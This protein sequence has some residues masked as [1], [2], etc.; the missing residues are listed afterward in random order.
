M[1]IKKLFIF[2]SFF[3]V[4]FILSPYSKSDHWVSQKPNDW[5]FQ[6]RAYP[7]TEINHEQYVEGIKHLQSIKKTSLWKDEKVWEFAGPTNIGGRLTDVEMHPDVPQTMFYAAASGGVFKSV[8]GGESFYPVFDDALSLSIGD[9]AIAPSDPDIIYVGTGEA[10]CGGG[11]LAYEGVG[12]FRSQDNGETWDFAGLENSRN[13]GRM[14]VDPTDPQTIYVAAMGSLFAN[15]PDRGIYKSTDAG[16]TW[17]KVLFVNDSTGGIDLVIHPENPDILYAAMWERV[18]RPHRRSY[19]GTGCGIFRSIDAGLSWTELT[20]GLPS[21]SPYVGRIGID[22]CEADPDVLY[23]IYA[24]N[25]GYFEGIYKTSDMG[26]TWQA[27]NDAGLSGCYSSYGWWFGR[28]EVDPVDPD[29]AYAIAFDL[30]KTASGGNSWSNISSYYTHVDQ[31][32]LYIQPQNHDNLL[33][34]NDGGL[35]FSSNGGSSWAIL[36]ELPITQ[37][38]TCE[39]DYQYPQRLYG[40]TQDNGTNRTMSGSLDDWQ[41]IY[42]G[43]GFYALVDPQD[44]SYVYAEYQYGN[45]VRSTNGGNSFYSAMTG[46]SSGDRMNWNTPVVFDPNNPSVLYYGANRLYKSTNRAQNWNAI[47]NDLSN[48]S[49]NGNL[50]YGTI[51]TIDVSPL[52]ANLIYVGTDDG[53]VWRTDDGGTNWILLS[54]SLPQRWITRVVSD[55]VTLD[56]LYVTLSGFRWNEFLPH[57]YKSEDRGNTWTAIANGLPELPVNDLVVDPDNEEKLYLA[58]DA[59]VFVSSNGGNTWGIM[60]HGLPAVVINDLEIHQ[61]SRKLVAAT[62]GRSMYT[63]DLH[64]D[65]ITGQNVI[66]KNNIQ[67]EVYPNPARDQLTVHFDGIEEVSVYRIQ[68]FDNTGKLVLD[69]PNIRTPKYNLHFSSTDTLL[70]GVYFIYIFYQERIFKSKLIILP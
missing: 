24:D 58:T 63:Y 38:Y 62:F 69:R 56:R 15:S 25:I 54:E 44:N 55:P 9:I 45:F 1:I 47:S 2:L 4:S 12:V 13:I 28:I 5:F 46:I 59:A 65:T 21:P 60:G 14:V 10:N 30:Y 49:G 61:P 33:L 66:S 22:I 48:G 70:P 20:V 27:T 26:D 36:D 11:S 19:G 34:A 23:A 40:G 32:A 67:L 41:N 35:Y 68:L 52:D 53:N 42:G 3:G 43:D 64:Q 7:Y 8:D 6:Q 51:T 39:I 17:E 18:R 37:F 50:V 29:I 31:H 57:V 16:D